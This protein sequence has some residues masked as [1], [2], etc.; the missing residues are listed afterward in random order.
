VA[1]RA[2]VAGSSSARTRCTSSQ[3]HPETYDHEQEAQL[4][5]YRLGYHATGWITLGDAQLANTAAAQAR[6]RAWAARDAL[7]DQRRA[8]QLRSPNRCLTRTCQR[9]RTLTTPQRIEGGHL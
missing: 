5:A 4:V 1:S 6:A 8:P 9:A 7:D 2:G 3:G